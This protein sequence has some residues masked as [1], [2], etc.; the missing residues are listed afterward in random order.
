MKST[1]LQWGLGMIHA[2]PS[3][4]GA[5]ISA[6]EPCSLRAKRWWGCHQQQG[7]HRFIKSAKGL[8]DHWVQTSTNSWRGENISGNPTGEEWEGF[9]PCLIEGKLHFCSSTWLLMWQRKCYGRKST[10]KVLSISKGEAADT[11]WRK[12]LFFS[13]MT[14]MTELAQLSLAASLE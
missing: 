2:L 6:P 13:V 14:M 11:C 9:L 1:G 5:I 3:R 12:M 4:L 10:C 7:N 8:Q